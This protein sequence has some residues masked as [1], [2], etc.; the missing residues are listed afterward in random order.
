LVVAL[1]EATSLR[2]KVDALSTYGQENSYEI[3][4][5]KSVA[6]LLDI[7]HITR[8]VQAQSFSPDKILEL[9]RYHNFHYDYSICP[10]D[11][12]MGAAR[13]SRLI[14][15]GSAGEIYRRNCKPHMKVVLKNKDELWELFGDYHQKTDPLNIE[16]PYIRDKQQQD[17]RQL[18]MS[19]FEQGAD[20]NDISDIFFMR[21]RMPLWNGP[22]LNNIYGGVRV[23]PLANYHVAKLAFSK[24]Y[25]SRVNDR[26]H[27]E[28]L[29]RINPELC[30]APFL[31]FVWPKEFQEIAKK[32]GVNVA[33]KPYPIVGKPSVAQSNPIISAFLS[34]G[35]FKLMRS[36]MFDNPH[37][38]VFDILNKTAIEKVLVS[39]AAEV[40]GVVN[41]KQLFAMMGFQTILMND[42]DCRYEGVKVAPNYDGVHAQRLFQ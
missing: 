35:G 20:L 27:F 19:Y 36:Y 6:D 34:E 2:D 39:G 24:G 22:L 7:P 15:T 28:L 8:A 16:L 21:Y 10:P 4:V 5:G 12:L 1:V 18:A 40:K 11:G 37:S 32:R 3:Q 42:L 17:M 25:Q 23:Y 14:F 41:A 29:L 31:G 13:E 30:A 26:I 33:T 38:P 9:L